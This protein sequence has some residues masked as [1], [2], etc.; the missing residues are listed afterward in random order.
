MGTS[1]DASLNYGFQFTY[2]DVWYAAGG[3]D[4]DYS[5]SDEERWPQEE[6]ADEIDVWEYT[7][8]IE[9]KFGLV[10]LTFYGDVN[11]DESD[12][13]V[14][15]Y[16]KSNRVVSDGPITRFDPSWLDQASYKEEAALSAAFVKIVQDKGSK[17]LPI[18]YQ[19]PGWHLC[20]DRG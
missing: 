12:Q 18:K 20:W 11:W 7:D 9:K 13:G 16:V 19:L 10:G 6:A 4:V 3:T 15:L 14:L 17:G 5:L 8:V 1:V 2:D